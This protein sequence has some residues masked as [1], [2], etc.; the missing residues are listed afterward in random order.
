MQQGEWSKS[1]LHILIESVGG[2]RVDETDL[3]Y[4]VADECLYPHR[5]AT[6][7]QLGWNRQD[8]TKPEGCLI[9]SLLAIM[10]WRCRESNP[11]PKQTT[12]NIYKF[13]RWFEFR[14]TVQQ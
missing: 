8:L 1:P 2:S 14:R 5:S 10:E 3:R 7:P 13:S 4:V 12:V 11:G 9:S 6:I